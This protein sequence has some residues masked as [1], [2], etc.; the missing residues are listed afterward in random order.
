MYRL[1]PFFLM[2][3]LFSQE[4]MVSYFDKQIYHQSKMVKYDVTTQIEKEDLDMGFMLG[5]SYPINPPN[6]PVYLLG[7]TSIAKWNAYYDEVYA[8]ATYLSARFSPMSVVMLKPYVEV[9][10]AGPTYFSKQTLGDLE[11]GSH[12]MY[13]NYISA[14]IQFGTL[15]FDVKLIN[16]S[17]ALTTAFTKDSHYLPL[18][19]SVGM[20]Y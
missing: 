12:V 6:S 11:F 15:L 9:S 14:G 3:P 18:I 10:L 5:Y 1:I 17:N 8:Y 2:L 16:Y 4:I 20:S 19:L 13:Q 7:G